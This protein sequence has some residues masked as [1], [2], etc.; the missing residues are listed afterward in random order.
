MTSRR[1][2]LDPLQNNPMGYFVLSTDTLRGIRPDEMLTKDWTNKPPLFRHFGAKADNERT[3][4][5]LCR[6]GVP[7]ALRSAIW[8][9]NILRKARPNQT[10]EET[11]E[12]GTLMKVEV[13]DHGWDIVK[14]NAFPDQSDEDAAT[15]PDFG[16]DPKK[17]EALL[18]ED[19][20]FHDDGLSVRG[21]KGVKALTKV[22]FA[23]HLQLGIEYCP[24]L[25]DL[26]GLFLSV[27][28]ESYAYSMIREMSNKSS[29]YFPLSKNQHYA[30]CKTF[31][32]LMIK[33]YPQAASRMKD[34][35][36]LSADGLDP[37]FRRFFVTI[38]KRDQVLRLIDIYTI[39]GSKVI[40]RM[41]TSITC[42]C[43]AYMTT[44]DFRNTDDFWRGVRR[45]AHSNNFNFEV[46]LRQAYGFNGRRYKRRRSF[47]RRKF[48]ERVME[49]N[50]QWA[51]KYTSSDYLELSIRPLGFV[52]G[53]IP[54]VLAK[55]AS[56]RLTLTKY[57][58][59]AYKDTK[60]KLVYSS[61]EHGRSLKT[62]YKHCA[63]IKHTI[64]LMEVL[65]TGGTIGMFATE[66]WHNSR[67]VY[68]DGE[69]VLFRLSPDPV[70]YSWSHQILA[71]DF[72]LDESSV[73]SLLSN[74]EAL[75]CE[76]M[77]SKDNFL[78][79]GSNSD[80]TS[81]LRLN[82]D[83]SKGTSAKARGFNNEP[84]AGNEYPEFDIGL[85][86]TYQLIREIDGKP[87]HRDEEIWNNMF[88]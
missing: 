57:L 28:P 54:I 31:A 47:P 20:C 45:V 42:L 67:K 9:T 25:P 72:S 79:M 75:L 64:T 76:F 78:S 22:L 73:G 27:M 10:M 65:Q 8:L 61:N 83:L 59:F 32:D 60:I 4:K 21:V 53:D 44:S 29:Y 80:G 82:E 46:L 52:E 19:H 17:T 26:T 69:C 13:L 37:L 86:E 58:P 23:T 81:G 36:A 24:L 43:I 49:Y 7:P 62:F 71:S 63:K 2:G 34:C 51:E 11:Y 6:L 87:I 15:I 77:V 50:E 55:Q 88:D 12:Y 68:G 74:E 41:G 14:K 66:T 84:L 1:D 35:G 30:W 5:R 40:F 3:L 70:C 16:L 48:I 56:A 18:I 33:M 85:V 38:L 39:E